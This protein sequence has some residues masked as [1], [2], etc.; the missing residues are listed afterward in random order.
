MG[1][2]L[3]DVWMYSIEKQ[4]WTKPRVDGEPPMPRWQHGS[5]IHAGVL[6]CYGGWSPGSR[7]SDGLFLLHLK[8]RNQRKLRWSKPQTNAQDLGPLSSFAMVSLNGTLLLCG[9]KAEGAHE[10]HMISRVDP[11]SSDFEFSV[12]NLAKGAAMYPG[13]GLT[14]T[15]IENGKAILLFGGTN[16]LGC[17][18]KLLLPQ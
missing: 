8:S 2:K 16:Y 17:Y 9:G 15:C 10:N 11:S 5:C 1:E 6:Y 13:F 4:L 18:H 12:V 3:N 7:A 14:A